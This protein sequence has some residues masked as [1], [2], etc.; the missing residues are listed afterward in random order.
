MPNATAT[1]NAS[2]RS[3]SR[4]P[5]SGAVGTHRARR[6]RQRRLVLARRA[7]AAPAPARRHA[8]RR[9]GPPRQRPR[10]PAWSIRPS[11]SSW[12]STPARWRRAL[13]LGRV[14][15]AGQR[16]A[17]HRALLRPVRRLVPARH[18]RTQLR[19]ALLN[20]CRAVVL[21][22]RAIRAVNPQPKLV[23]TDDLGKTYGTPRWATS[24]RSTTSA[25]GSAGTCC[26][27]WS[28]PTTRCGTTCSAPASRR[29]SCSGS[30][31]TPARPTSSASITTSPANA[32]WTTASSAIRNASARLPRRPACRH[33]GAARAGHADARHRPLLKETWERYGLPVAVTEAHIDA[34]R[35]DQLRWL[36]E[37][38]EAAQAARNAGADVRAVTVWALLGSYD[39]NCLVTACRAITSRARSTCVRPSRARPRWPA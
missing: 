27:A 33:R 28:A 30:A 9:P 24:P 7:P 23:Q 14:L 38:W 10:T 32:G 39:W 18:R 25:A 31:T 20:Q 21:S 3:A 15:H 5:L 8:D 6:H 1:S 17:D 22:M 13:S 36:L 12:P 16:A 37:I 19:R 26:A 35:E 11:R 34:N 4:N 2:P 29:R